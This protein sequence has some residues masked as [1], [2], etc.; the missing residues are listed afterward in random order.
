[1]T[2]HQPSHIVSFGP[3]MVPSQVNISSSFNGFACI[4]WK[5]QIL[6]YCNNNKLY[7]IMHL[8]IYDYMYR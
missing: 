5:G 3:F 7:K 4:P 8:C 6:L 2:S 1:M